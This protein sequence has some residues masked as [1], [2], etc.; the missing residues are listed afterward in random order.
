MSRDSAPWVVLTPT[1]LHKAPHRL[2]QS[3]S[4]QWYLARRRT[5]W[6]PALPD[7][8]TAWLA[9]LTICLSDCPWSLWRVNISFLPV[10]LR[11]TGRVQSI[12]W[13]FLV[14]KVE[15]LYL[16]HKKVT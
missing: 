2:S 11:F 15:V 5:R 6:Q 3:P 9:L 8:L 4:S 12:D 7:Y 13:L 10:L 16:S 14:A 1:F